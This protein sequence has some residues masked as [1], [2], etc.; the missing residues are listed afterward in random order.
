[1]AGRENKET[2][3]EEPS[4]GGLSRGYKRFEVTFTHTSPHRPLLLSIQYQLRTLL[5]SSFFPSV[6]SHYPVIISYMCFLV[7]VHVRVPLSLLSLPFLR[8]HGI[9]GCHATCRWVYSMTFLR[10]PFEYGMS[11]TAE[12]HS[13]GSISMASYLKISWLSLVLS[14]LRL[15]GSSD[16]PVG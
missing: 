16:L 11:V 8:P 2:L 14:V 15:R 9:K 4:H 10:V 3:E 13:F 6:R 1:M 12:S 7:V 5:C